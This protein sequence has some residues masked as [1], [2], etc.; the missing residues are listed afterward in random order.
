MPAVFQPVAEFPLTASGKI[1]RSALPAIDPLDRPALRSPRTAAEQT[2]A[3]IWRDLLGVD[4]VGVDDDFYQLGGSSLVTLALESR[5][6]GAG[7][8]VTLRDLLTHTT[9]AA[10]A[11]LVEAATPAAPPVLPV[12]RDRPLPLSAAQ[13]RLWMLDQLDP[14]SKEWVVPVHVRLP[15]AIHPD[16]VR[17]ALH[18]LEARHEPLRT[19]Y[20]VVDGVARQQV[21]PPGDVDLEVRDVSHGGLAELITDQL[22]RGF[23]LHT[24]PLWR[25]GLAVAAGRDHLLVLAVHHIASDAGS[26]DVLERDLRELCDAAAQG[27]PADLA[28]LRVQYADYAVWQQRHLTDE[29][30]GRELAYWRE[31]LAGMPQLELP[32]D[33]PRP[34][35]RDAQG[36]MLGFTVDGGGRG[37]PDRAGPALRGQ[38]V[39]DPAHR[40]RHACSPAT[41]GSGT[42]RSA[43]PPPGT[44]PPSW[45]RRPGSS[46]TRWCCAAPWTRRPA[47]PRRSGESATVPS[48]PW[49]TRTCPSTAWCT[50][51]SASGTCPAPPSTRWR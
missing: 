16:H 20:L 36:R 41:P 9:V 50:T 29:V 21:V 7:G 2:V 32:L 19:R 42:C 51:W 45:T 11:R 13:H 40:L 24:G 14:R 25:A 30:V 3:A 8:A 18:A 31:T 4:E 37:R 22:G 27:R 23:D 49:P 39:H 34:A 17:V 43:P 5:L 47:S 15:A 44:G 10:Q 6:S 12:G 35:R 46:S 1:D 33:R 28:K 26:A 38:P 48:P